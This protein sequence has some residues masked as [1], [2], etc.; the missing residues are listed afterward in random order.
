MSGRLTGAAIVVLG[1][2]VA[3]LPALTWYS[4][5]PAGARAA[6]S[7]LAGAGE[8][9]L[10]PPLGAVAVAAGGALARPGRVPGT[11]EPAPRW[12]GPAAAAAGLLALAFALGAAVA[13]DLDLRVVLPEGGEG[14]PAPVDLEAPALIAAAAGALLAIAGAAATWTG[15][16]R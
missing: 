3:V 5:G 8:L 13:P 16:R 10:L 12:A 1:A 2:L 14:V 9:W 15:R 7:G 6:A 11:P 4:A